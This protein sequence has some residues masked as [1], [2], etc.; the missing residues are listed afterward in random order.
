MNLLTLE[1]VSKSFTERMLFDH[2]S[3]G[4]NEG[5][6]IGVI[7][8]NGTG[9]STLLKIIAGLEDTD[10]GKRTCGNKLRIAYLPQ[11]PVFD[12]TKSILANVC[13]GQTAKES[14]RNITGEARSMLLKFG[15]NN[16]E[17][18]ASTLSGGQKKRA[19]LVRTLLTESDL[20]VLDEPT[21]HLDSDMTEWLEEYLNKWKGAFIM[22]T[23]DR[24]FLDR[25][26]NKIVELDK[27]KLYSYQ[28]NYSGFIA[29][30]AER[31][32]MALATERK[33]KTLFK[34]ELAWMQRG[35]RARSTKQKAHI[36]RFEALRDREKIVEDGSV[37]INALSSRMGKKTIELYDI[38]KSYNGVTLFEPF[39]YILLSTDRIGIVGHNGCG[40]STL[41]NIITGKIEPDTGYVDMGTTMKI[42]YFSQ[43]NEALDPN[44]TVLQYVRDTAEYIETKEGTM[45]ASAMCEQFLFDGS[46]QYTRIEKLSGG[47][48][49]RLYLLKVLMEAP[50]VLILDEPTNDLD[51]QTLTILES[52][53]EDYPGIV[54]T[55]SHDRYF[56]DK[57]AT[58]IFSF[59][60]GK[61][62][63]YEGN[64]SDFKEAQ[65]ERGI[66]AA[67]SAPKNSIKNG[68]NTSGAANSATDNP[69]SADSKSTWKQRDSKL[70][71][72]YKEQKEYETIDADIAALEEKI[73]NLEMEIAGAAT[74]YSRLTELMTEKEQAETA[75]EEKMDRWVYLNDLAE[76][77][78]AAKK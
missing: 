68:G 49:R 77:I 11:T 73:A 63:R 13:E 55:V 47:E 41:L 22:I 42:G 32:E 10:E 52:Y 58:R 15:I 39:R 43:E 46:M 76:Q 60:N 25:V 75:L 59:E 26:T 44:L 31:E 23:H 19:A 9:K 8:I 71:F 45:S 56:L 2:I 51:I 50:N 66:V 72:S 33:A 27:G 37:E 78:E 12:D 67:N 21:N 1:N 24:Y 61:I 35:A 3:L 48:K 74:Q 38:C 5:D 14:Y 4:I 70:K 65:K 29:L 6:K 7:G 64:Y 28:T 16:P 30:K 36:Q 20:L 54:V 57:I 18:S 40:K 17:G 62:A 34:T 53:L 69:D